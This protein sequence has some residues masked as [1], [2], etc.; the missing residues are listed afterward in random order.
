M[1]H[2][3]RPDSSKAHAVSPVQHQGR[4]GVEERDQCEWVQI[5]EMTGT[6]LDQPSK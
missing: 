4:A 6:L 5:T 1:G 3:T 2:N